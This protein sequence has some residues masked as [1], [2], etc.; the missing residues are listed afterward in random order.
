MAKT[1]KTQPKNV[2]IALRRFVTEGTIDA[3]TARLLKDAVESAARIRDSVRS[4][5]ENYNRILDA[6]AVVR[7]D[8]NNI[9]DDVEDVTNYADAEAE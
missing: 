8:I 2:L 3:G 5:A 9:L 6:L 4:M 7:G 1:R